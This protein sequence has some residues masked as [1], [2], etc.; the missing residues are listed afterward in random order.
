MAT[1]TRPVAVTGEAERPA[2]RPGMVDPYET[3]MIAVIIIVGAV[4]VSLRSTFLTTSNLLAIVATT[5][6][7]GIMAVTS[8]WVMIAGGIDLSV[9]S[10]MALACCVG[11]LG[12]QHWGNSLWWVTILVA[13]GVGAVV[14]L[15]NGTVV[16]LLPMVPPFIITLG[17]LYIVAGVAIA[18]GGSYN[19][20]ILG[21]NVLLFVAQGKVG[22]VPVPAILFLGLAVV[23]LFI[24]RRSTFGR[25]VYAIGANPIAA[26]IFGL[27]V[28]RVRLLTYIISGAGAGFAGYL[29]AI[30]VEAAASYYGQNEELAVITA[31]LI[32]GTSMYGGD[33]SVAR[34]VLGAIVVGEISDGL[35]VMNVN[36]NW[37]VVAMGALLI[38][39]VSVSLAWR[40]TRTRGGMRWDRTGAVRT[41][42]DGLSRLLVTG[43]KS[44]E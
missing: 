29:A 15:C 11:A 30:Q 34:S 38:V 31:I 33:G 36:Q 40:K 43:N 17:S 5:A 18:V 9:G 24:E 12:L 44:N 28:S 13:I 32:G 10:I 39:A 41:L 21:P 20:P 37:Q 42:R 23:F 3:G 35:G 7:V 2:K 8:T 4:F 19:L 27:P 25:H 1:R 6:V 26:R 14:G 22:Q 16:V